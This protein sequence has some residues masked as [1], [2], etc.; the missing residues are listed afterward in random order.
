MEASNER[1]VKIEGSY[2]DIFLDQ[3]RNSAEG[4]QTRRIFSTNFVD[5]LHMLHTFSAIMTWTVWY[6]LAEFLSLKRCKWFTSCR[7]KNI[8]RWVFAFWNRF[9]HSRERALRSLPEVRT[10][11]MPSSLKQRWPLTGETTTSTARDIGRNCFLKKW[12]EYE[13]RSRVDCWKR[14]PM[15]HFYPFKNDQRSR[16]SRFRAARSCVR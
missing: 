8:F 15:G 16:R 6:I 13:K 14:S 4:Y 3:Y 9:R 7:S 2:C 12:V 10:E 5:H 11:F 1:F